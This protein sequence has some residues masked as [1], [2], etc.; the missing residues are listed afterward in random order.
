MIEFCSTETQNEWLK[1]RSE[2]WSDD[3]E[4][5]LQ[6]DIDDM[7]AEPDHF[8]QALFRLSDGE[9][10]GFVEASVRSDYVNGTSTTPVVFLEGIYVIPKHRGYGIA[11]KLIQFITDWAIENGYSE[12][13]S[14]VLLENTESQ[15]MHEALGFEE[16]E[17]VVYYCKSLV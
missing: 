5:D 8:V 16:T 13:A 17:R 12:L 10:A 15:Q 14:D 3:T 1:L 6:L 4:E 9:V 7:L 11:A 2:L